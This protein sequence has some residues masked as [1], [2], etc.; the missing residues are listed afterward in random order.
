MVTPS[1]L[2]R[3][4]AVLIVL[5]VLVVALCAG[6]Y[7][8][9]QGKPDASAQAQSA[10]AKGKATKGGFDANRAVPVT[11]EAA[12][13]GEINIYLT[14]LGTVVPLRTVTVRSRVDGELMRVNFNEGQ[15]VKAGDLL[16]EI[17]QRP[18]QVQLSQAEG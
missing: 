2:L 17:D 18:Y 1:P 14:G 8:Y 16:A 12:R 10:K 3:R 6:A 13:K 11:A 4:P 9:F 7:W 15:M 5:A